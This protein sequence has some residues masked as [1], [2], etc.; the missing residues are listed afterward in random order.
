MKLVEDG[1]QRISP[2]IVIEHQPL[3]AIAP[4]APTTEPHADTE[5]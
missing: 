4:P 1:V 5:A 2:R 3:E